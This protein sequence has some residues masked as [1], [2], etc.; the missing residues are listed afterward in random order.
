MAMLPGVSG[1]MYKG[2]KRESNS[3]WQNSG[4]GLYMTSQICRNGGD[5]LIVSNGACLLLSA[6]SK[7]DLNVNYKGTSLRLR[8]NTTKVENYS[9]MLSK[10]RR[11]GAAVAKELSGFYAIEPSVAS[12]MLMRDFQGAC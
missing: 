7:E 3:V 1:K 11:E 5:F 2:V 9:G 6:D 12:T 10:F 4:Y 8:I